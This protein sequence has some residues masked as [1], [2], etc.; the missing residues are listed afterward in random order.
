MAEW[1]VADTH[2]MSERPVYSIPIAEQEQGDVMVV[3]PVSDAAVSLWCNLLQ[4]KE[5]LL[6]LLKEGESNVMRTKLDNVDQQLYNV[7]SFVSS[8]VRFPLNPSL[9]DIRSIL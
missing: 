1:I 4:Q 2:V 9:T 5:T 8:K 3:E 7:S 6:A